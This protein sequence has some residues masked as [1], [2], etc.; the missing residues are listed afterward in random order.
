MNIGEKIR[1]LRKSKRMTLKNL[2]EAS[3]VALATLSRIETG[4]MTGTVK[5]HQK[6]AS[7][8]GISISQLYGDMK[9]ENRP[10][11]FQSIKNRTDLFIHNDKASY[12]MLT[13]YVLSKKMMPVVLKIS[14]GGATSPEELPKE[15]EKFIYILKGEC[16]IYAGADNYTLKKAETLYF[17]AS[18]RHY[19][20]NT[21][22]EE[23]H[24][25]C[26]TTPPAL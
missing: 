24:L 9:I 13:S 8:L 15:S 3:S 6:I 17:D 26:I 11:E 25:I 5:S 12:H 10:V 22:N 16:K 18:L 4:A 20:E 1:N 23:A 19:F 2:S 7:V 21:G 14:P